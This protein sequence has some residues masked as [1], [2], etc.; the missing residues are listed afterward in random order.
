M[1][2]AMPGVGAMSS[3]IVM[4]RVLRVANGRA[5]SAAP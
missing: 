5:P 2:I 3:S 4:S 1:M